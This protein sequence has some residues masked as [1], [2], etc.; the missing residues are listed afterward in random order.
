MSY[1]VRFVSC[2]IQS[3]REVRSLP[4]SP[5]LSKMV[6]EPSQQKSSRGAQPGLLRL[7]GRLQVLPIHLPLALVPVQRRHSPSERSALT[8][9]E[10]RDTVNKPYQTA[11]YSSSPQ[12]ATCVSTHLSRLKLKAG[13][14]KSGKVSILSTLYDELMMHDRRDQARGVN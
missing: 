6:S 5:S 4:Y 13:R 2:P 11:T 1:T 7:Q 9:E 12:P 3:G 14:A 8:K 10:K